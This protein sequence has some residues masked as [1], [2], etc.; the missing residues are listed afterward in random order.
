M[1]SGSLVVAVVRETVFYRPRSGTQTEIWGFE[2]TEAKVVAPN[3]GAQTAAALDQWLKLRDSLAWKLRSGKTELAA[4][5][6][7]ALKAELPK[8]LETAAVGPLADHCRS[9]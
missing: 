5:Q 7:T 8:L 1:A 4:E 9:R 6:I 2:L 3:D